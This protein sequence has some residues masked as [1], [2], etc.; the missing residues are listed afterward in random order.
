MVIGFDGYV[1]SAFAT[2]PA[3]Q[4]VYL[5]FQ[6]K[7]WQWLGDAVNCP[8]NIN[9][10]E[11]NV[12]FHLVVVAQQDPYE[13]SGTLIRVYRNGTEVYQMC[14]NETLPECKS[15]SIISF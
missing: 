10:T 13:E 4:P 12:S 5:M 11:T 6:D 2:A 1:A 8:N 7:S 9:I 3:N 15:D 14:T